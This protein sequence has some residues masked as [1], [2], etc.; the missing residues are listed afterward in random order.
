MGVVTYVGR[1]PVRRQV[2]TITIGSSTAAQ[3]FKAKVGPTREVSYTAG[4]G[5]TTTTIAV[6]LQALCAAMTDGEFAELDWG[7]VPTTASFT[8]TG[9]D[10]G[11]PFTLAVSGTGTISGG[12][13][14]VT[15]LSPSDVA[16]GANYSGGALP[17]DA[18]DSLVIE[19]TAVPLLYN[20]DA[21]AAI[22]LASPGL[23]RR[24]T[25]AGAIGLPTTNAGG[26]PEYRPTQLSV[27]SATIDVQ[28][29]RSD[30]A[31]GIKLLATLTGSAVTAV[32]RGDGSNTGV[33]AEVVEISG[34]P[35]S[36]VV[37]VAESSVAVCPLTGQTGTVA[38]L[39][40]TNSTV[41]V[42]AGCTL[43]GPSLSQCDA[44]IE[45]NWSGT[46]TMDGG[47]VEVNRAAAGVF[48]IEAGT[49]TWL[50]TGNPGSGCVIGSNG[51]L[52]LSQAPK[53]LT[54]GGTVSLY[55]G[56]TLNDPAGRGGNYAVSPV[57]CTLQEATWVTP[58]GGTY[59]K[60]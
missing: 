10:D 26:Y 9:P 38:T 41:R 8:V 17:A 27:K 56:A 50:S 52:D 13:P 29:S 22:T 7:S 23:T 49:M 14:T 36:S 40:G 25:H 2:N 39:V 11:A 44:L 33:G 31:G 42:G 35:A 48:T 58:N 46:L 32:I 30:G 43:T 57:H 54:F 18:T 3:T 4:S 59:T 1:Q 34:L 60:S 47:S 53:G 6:A 5:E 55:A 21:L 20:L 51:T 15:P 12:T 45:A 24:G 19:N 28:T 16:D 37:D